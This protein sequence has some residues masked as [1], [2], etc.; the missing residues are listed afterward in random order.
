MENRFVRQSFTSSGSWVCPAGVTKVLV[1]GMGGGAGGGGGSNATA[2]AGGAGGYGAAGVTLKPVLLDV[3]PNTTYTITIGAGGSGGTNTASTNA[4]G[5][6]GSAGG[7]TSFGALMTWKGAPN[8]TTGGS[9][10]HY[11]TQA[12]GYVDTDFSNTAARYLQ[13][14]QATAA[15]FAFQGTPKASYQGLVSSNGTFVQSATTGA[16]GAGG[17]SGEGIGGNGGS[18]AG[19]GAAGTSGISAAANSGAGGGGGAGGSTTSQVGG[20]GGNGGS[21]MLIICWAE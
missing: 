14:T 12:H 5:A 4:A 8:N 15:N 19:A 1:W 13:G 7:D 10:S 11:H 20:S 9:Y 18:N 21:G 16:L 6:V 2:S 3:V 17:C